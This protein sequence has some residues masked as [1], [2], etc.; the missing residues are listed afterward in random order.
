MP[1]H[2]GLDKGRCLRAFRRYDSVCRLHN[3]AVIFGDRAK[4]CRRGR[5]PMM[6]SVR[7]KRGQFWS[8]RERGGE[9]A[10]EGPGPAPESPRRRYT[11]DFRKER[12][13][14]AEQKR[15]NCR[16][17]DSRR[18]V[19]PIANDMEYLLR[20]RLLTHK[21]S[22]VQTVVKSGF[23]GIVP[24]RVPF[25]SPSLISSWTRVSTALLC[26]AKPIAAVLSCGNIG[27]LRGTNLKCIREETSPGRG[28]S[29]PPRAAPRETRVCGCSRMLRERKTGTFQS[30]FRLAIA[31]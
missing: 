24:T 29:D 21:E 15:P 28:G 25:G 26:I 30:I 22:C 13:P 23:T 19:D 9:V 16:V 6:P 8:V 20:M 10:R 3:P 14:K 18:V 7:R 11:R 17:G 31:I 1:S 5:S 4:S 12:A 2:K 27:D